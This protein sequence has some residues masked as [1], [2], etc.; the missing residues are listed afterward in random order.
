MYKKWIAFFT[1]VLLFATV[2]TLRADTIDDL[3]KS[4][5][6]KQRIPGLS[7]AVIK[8]GQIVKSQGYGLAN[9]ELN[10]PAT[11]QTVYKI[12]S[13][14]K[15]F[16]AAGI[17]LLVQ[18]N[19][20]SLD[21]KISKFLEGTPDNWKEITIRHLLTHT[22]GIVREAPG[23]DPF[24]IQNNAD[25]IKTAYSLPLNFAPGER[26]EYSNTGYFALA[27][28]IRQ[29]SGKPWE[30]YLSEQVFK[31]LDMSSTRTTTMTEIV[32]NRAN[33][34]I[35]RNDKLQNADVFIAL[36]PSGAFLSSVVDLAKWDAALYNDKILNQ[37]LRNEMWS[38]AKLNNG[39]TNDYGF[40]WYLDKLSGH[41]LVRHGGSL[42]GFRAEFVR[43]VDD[44][45]SI[46]I[47]ANGDNADLGAISVKIADL[48]IPNLIPKR[49]VKAVDSKILDTYVGQYQPT[50]SVILT[51]TREG[52]KLIFQQGSN[53]NK[54]EL[55]PENETDFFMQDNPRLIYRFIK[56]EQGEVTH[57]TVQ[58][59]GREVARAKKIK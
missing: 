43:F 3:V 44:K 41:K 54:Q 27:E 58:I 38:P 50:P 16:I 2:A 47:L 18:E 23:F 55:L 22:S 33:G 5:M 36:R 8:D 46:A 7:L 59:E 26:F 20:I 29:S 9:V 51:V 39:K 12:A 10:V 28:I 13:V 37:S 45:I 56:N 1:F 6:Q 48:F 25:V 52:G 30:D 40:G 19:K 17:L 42:P 14:S 4:E 15:Q 34:Y 11:P 35:W 49:T 57:L 24:K 53:P 32:Q 31:P 21:D